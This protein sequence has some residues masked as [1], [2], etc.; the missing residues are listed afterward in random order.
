MHTLVQGQVERP[1]AIGVQRQV[2]VGAHVEAVREAGDGGV[3]GPYHLVEVRPREPVPAIGE[4]DPVLD[5]P[6]LDRGVQVAPGRVHP[7]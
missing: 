6:A 4:L 5:V 7:L 1:C 2:L 3:V